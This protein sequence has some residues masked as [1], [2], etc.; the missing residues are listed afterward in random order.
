MDNVKLVGLSSFILYTDYKIQVAKF[1]SRNS[2][3]CM[4]QKPALWCLP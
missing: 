1:L 4:K 2:P 3:C